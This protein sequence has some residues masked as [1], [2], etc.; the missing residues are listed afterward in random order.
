[1]TGEWRMFK[2]VLSENREDAELYDKHTLRLHYL[3]TRNIGESQG[4]IEQ[5]HSIRAHKPQYFMS[6]LVGSNDARD[7]EVPDLETGMNLL[8]LMVIERTKQNAN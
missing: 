7:V 3:S 5:R 2:A 1:M 6:C 4:Y 8:Q